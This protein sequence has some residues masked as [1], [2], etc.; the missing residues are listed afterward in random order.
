M[1][2]VS[3][4]P[5][6]RDGDAIRDGAKAFNVRGLDEGRAVIVY[7]LT[8]SAAKSYAECPFTEYVDRRAERMPGLD[9]YDPD[10]V[11]PQVLMEEFGWHFGC[12]DCLN[13]VY[14]KPG[15]AVGATGDERKR[16][17]PVYRDDGVYHQ[18]CVDESMSEPE[19]TLSSV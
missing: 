17:A 7:A 8:R 5:D 15:E 10:E 16:M 1:G 19:T 3:V 2:L 13:F 18:G 11:T 4:H 6:A 14:A 9:E 12:R